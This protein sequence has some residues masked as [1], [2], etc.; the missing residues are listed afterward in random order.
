MTKSKSLV[1]TKKR[2]SVLP[3]H[4]WRRMGESLS[5]N[6]ALPDVKVRAFDKQGNM[7][8]KQCGMASFYLRQTTLF[9]FIRSYPWSWLMVISIVFYLVLV[10]GITG[11]YYGWAWACGGPD[12]TSAIT[13]LY[14]TVV[15]LA[16]NGGYMG[17]A[18][19][20][21]NP[22]NVCYYGRTFIVMLASFTNIILVG[23]I[24]AL[25]VG[26]AE[27]TGKF[28]NRIIFSNF[29]TLTRATWQQKTWELKFRMANIASKKPL[30]QGQLH[31]FCIFLEPLNDDHT[32]IKTLLE[33][34]S[35]QCKKAC[36]LDQET[37]PMEALSNDAINETH[38]LTSNSA[39][40]SAS[41][42]SLSKTSDPK[43]KDPV[44]VSEFLEKLSIRGEGNIDQKESPDEA[45]WTL[46][47]EKNVDT[48]PFP[49]LGH[50][51][52]EKSDEDKKN[53]SSERDTNP[54]I[55]RVHSDEKEKPPRVY[56][57]TSNV[58]ECE[59]NLL[60][61]QKRSGNTLQIKN[62][63]QS[64]TFSA[65]VDP[66][67][68]KSHPNNQHDYLEEHLRSEEENSGRIQQVK[69]RVVELQWSCSEEEFLDKENRQLSLWYP[70]TICHVVDKHSP[71][72]RFF[73][74]QV[75]NSSFSSSTDK[76]K[77]SLDTSSTL[78][79][80]PEFFQIVAV[81]DGIE[82]ES[83]AT[84]MEKHAYTSIDILRNYKFSNNL[85]NMHTESSEIHLNYNF[86]NVV[87]P[88]TEDFIHR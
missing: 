59:I 21:E 41:N 53:S 67:L 87:Y 52:D 48:I 40:V 57:G 9:Y 75:K 42:V 24:A 56:G 77:H 6:M 31:L 43:N 81:F 14:F 38:D 16:A 8:T 5:C 44:R 58:E 11:L 54:F 46:P 23:L 18:A 64:N 7:T 73:Y 83:G 32:L 10:M 82:T 79:G 76:D 78:I 35:I 85:M 15:S 20:M 50:K 74:N 25:V 63:C 60:Y 65:E 17:E 62:R 45:E 12:S 28:G 88:I 84:I 86:F 27:S 4:R 71:L 66:L 1:S 26:K 72:Y 80:L 69:L 68:G 49:L 51:E 29:C 36:A 55:I 2:Q 34:E 22:S 39:F 47:M 3:L 70:S 30:A 19:S 33:K 37:A 13:S 61:T